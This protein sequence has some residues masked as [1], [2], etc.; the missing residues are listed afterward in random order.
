MGVKSDNPLVKQASNK[1]EE[2]FKKNYSFFVHFFYGQ[3]S[4]VLKCKNCGCKRYNFDPYQIVTLSMDDHTHTLQDCFEKFTK[5][6]TLFEVNCEKCLKKTTFLRKNKIW[7]VPQVLS[8]SLNRY[9]N[10]GNKIIKLIDYP[11]Q[12][13]KVYCAEKEGQNK[14]K[15]D[16]VGVINHFGTGQ[17]GHYTA[18]CKDDRGK[19]FEYDDDEVREIDSQK[20]VTPASYLLIYQRKKISLEIVK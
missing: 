7:R 12:N 16:L 9:D 5:T 3:Y 6:E 1:Y 2:L 10:Y 18:F 15:F 14:I 17:G 4:I 19:W 8:I 13:F 20:V 11:L